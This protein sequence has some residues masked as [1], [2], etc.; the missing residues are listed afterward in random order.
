MLKFLVGLNA[1]CERIKVQFYTVN[2]NSH[3]L[4]FLDEQ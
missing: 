3:K 4:M 2:N 1:L